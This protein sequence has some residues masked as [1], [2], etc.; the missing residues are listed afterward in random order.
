V[1]APQGRALAWAAALAC[2]ACASV[3]ESPPLG[4]EAGAESG[5]R[6]DNLRLGSGNSDET[7]VVLTLSGGGTRAAGLAYGVMRRLAEA[8]RPGGSSLLDE[9]DVISSVSGGSF[10]AAY[11]GAF[12]QQRFLASFPEEVL[13]RNLERGYVLR[14]L[15]PWSWW[16]L[17]SWWY[18]RSDLA[19]EYYDDAIF[20]GATFAGLAERPYLQIN[21]TDLSLGARFSFT[22]HHFDRICSDVGGVRLSRAVTASSAFPIV[23][24]PLALRNHE[25]DA[26][27]GL[28]TPEWVEGALEHDLEVN[29]SRYDRAKA[30]AS[31]ADSRRRYVHLSDGGLADNIGLRGPM[32]GLLS[33]HADVP[34]QELLNETLSEERADG[35]RRIVMVVVD[36]KPEAEPELDDTA[37]APGFFT[38]LEAAATKPM[39]N[40]SADTVEI[41]R[42]FVD[43][44]Q[45]QFL[46][47][48]EA[49]PVTFYRIHVRFEAE[50]DLEKRRDLQEIGTRLALSPEEVTRVIQAGGRLLEASAQYRCLV[51]ALGIDGA[52]DEAPGGCPEEETR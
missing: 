25:E 31:Y 19:D 37:H 14:L 41:A 20:H 48:G 34:L 39:E 52:A 21:A 7:F 3:P 36:A 6:F 23:F 15:A 5:Y 22:Q 10:A 47:A 30:W 43:E 44:W 50:P 24:T 38:V 49:S 45:R 32:L 27:C 2:A 26:R 35:V 46:D 9:V 40:Y 8:Q 12:G 33:P 16:K 42:Q 18:G 11:Y 4:S 28:A 51:R 29:P 1:S 17:G 13:A